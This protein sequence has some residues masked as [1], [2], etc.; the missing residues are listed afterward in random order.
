MQ[1][2][3]APYDV[4]LLDMHRTFMFGVDRFDEGEDF[5]AAYRAHGGGGLTDA[6]VNRLILATN[7]IMFAKYQDPAYY[8]A[9][10]GVADTLG[11]L[12]VPV[13]EHEALTAAY[14]HHE[15]GEV[16]PD[17][18]ECI[19]IL[20]RRHR[21]GIVSNIFAPKSFWLGELDRTGVLDAVELFVASSDYDFM[22]PSPKIFRVALEYF[23]AEPGRVV[24]IGDSFRCDV[25]GA[26]AAD[27][28]AIWIDETAHAR[29][30]PMPPA[31]HVIPSLLA[32]TSVLR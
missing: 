26:A 5:A 4:V 3:L 10:P 13:G 31:R 18:A 32:L 8:E 23:G 24:Y 1:E 19:R 12:G 16:P 21:L 29:R 22:K 7:R 6:E 25:E 2:L 28:D 20:A 11:E 15:R 27:I 17:H 14:A 9:F 30:V